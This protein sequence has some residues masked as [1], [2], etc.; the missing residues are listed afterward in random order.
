MNP[1]DYDVN[2]IKKPLRGIRYNDTDELMNA[3]IASMLNLNVQ[4]S[5][6]GTTELV[7]RWQKVV[8]TNSAY[9]N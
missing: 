9:I 1:C 7:G 6:I 4:Q 8:D 2:K 3:T 5:L